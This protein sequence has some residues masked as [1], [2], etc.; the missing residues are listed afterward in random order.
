MHSE[1]VLNMPK[2][3][4][5]GC[6]KENAEDVEIIIEAASYK[7][8][9]RIANKKGI[10][11]S[12]VLTV[13]EPSQKQHD[14]SVLPTT[15][16]DS[17]VKTIVIISIVG[18]FLF[19]VMLSS[20][21]NTIGKVNSGSKDSKRNATTSSSSKELTRDEKIKKLFHWYDASHTNSINIIKSALHNPNSF[22]FIETTYQ[23]HQ[24]YLIVTTKYRAENGFGAIRTA[25]LKTKIDL[26]GKVLE[27]VGQS[28]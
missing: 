11:V 9:Q 19:I 16:L 27:I 2:F 17:K 12:D 21:V 7:D 8:A 18:I 24:T 10:L 20:L 22:E 1:G 4:V 5:K 14:T 26:N 13:E 6:L 15:S 3:R 23:D 25:W 28:D